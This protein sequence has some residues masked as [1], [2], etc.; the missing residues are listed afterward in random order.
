MTTDLLSP[1][2]GHFN[3]RARLFY[4]G[5][6]CGHATFDQSE[7]A[8]FLH[9]LR[10]GRVEL[11][12]STGFAATLTNPTLVFYSRPLSHWMDADPGGA[13]LVCA[14]VDFEHKSFNPIA[15]ALPSRF[16]CKLDELQQLL[17]LLEVL[18]AEAFSEAP[19]RQEVLNRLFELVLIQLLRAMIARGR[20]DVGL[21]RGLSHPLLSKAINA[22]H[23]N[24]ANNWS[25]EEL[26]QL[27]AMSR[28]SF[29]S[30][31]RLEIGQTPG[32]YLTTWRISTAQALLRQGTPLKLVAERVGYVSQAGFL[33]AFK[34]T[35]GMSPTT[36][37]RHCGGVTKGS[38][39]IIRDSW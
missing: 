10:S 33:R 5:H 18:F 12:D 24:P 29:A 19:G 2:L 16:L 22:I 28:S 1:I 4:S 27:A 37:L 39:T 15:L 25:L 7:D 20:T 9:L 8:G 35:L 23:A 26:A 14:S 32:D 30:T 36:W 11:R 34:A 6:L 21:L 3:V 17:P 31:F 13:D 38:K